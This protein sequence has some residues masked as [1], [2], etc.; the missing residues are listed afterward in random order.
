MAKLCRRAAA[1]A[2]CLTITTIYEKENMFD[3]LKTVTRFSLAETEHLV[4][5]VL[6]SEQL[7]LVAGGG[8]NSDDHQNAHK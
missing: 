3:F 8:A 7:L 4:G 2:A 5:I 1:C 6:T